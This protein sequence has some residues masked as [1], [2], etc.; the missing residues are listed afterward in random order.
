MNDTSKK[1]MIVMKN[2]GEIDV[3]YEWF[4]VDDGIKR[5]IPLNEVFDILPLRG[6]IEKGGYENVEFS[7]YAI[8]FLKFE[9]NAICWII[10]GPEYIVKI[11]GEAS[12]VAYKLEF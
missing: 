7:Y 4:F 10:G 12:D 3:E 9:I 6:V 2:N 8:P 11:K 5:D 1:Q